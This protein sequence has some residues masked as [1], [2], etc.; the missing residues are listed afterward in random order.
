MRNYSI[1]ILLIT[2]FFTSCT[3]VNS[4]SDDASIISFEI[5]SA[6]DGI[7][8]NKE[9]IAIEN[10]VVSIPLEYGR[11]LFPLKINAEIQFSSTTDKAISTDETPLNLKELVFNDVYTPQTFY[12]ISE[13]GVPHLATIML[14]DNP[15]AEIKSFTIKAI[16]SGEASV[17]PL[18][19][20]IRIILTKTP[21]W[22]LTIIPE[23]IKTEDAT[24]I[25]YVAG[26]PLTFQSPADNEKH[27]TLKAKNGDE[28][29]W[30]IQI[31]PSIE[32]SD[33]ESWINENTSSVNIDP[34][35]G[36]GLGWATANNPF[37]QGTRPTNNNNGKAAQMTT[38]IQ[39]LSGLGIGQLITAGT[40]FTGYFK[41]NI[42]SLN[43]PAA[44]TYFGIPF[45]ISP[46]S[47]SV[48]AKYI[49]GN[50]L[51]Q[52]KKDGGK[53]KLENLAGT[54]E[55]RIWVKLL[56]WNGTGALEFHDKPVSGLTELGMGELILDGKNPLYREWKN[57][58]LPIKYSPAHSLLSPT[59]IAI[60][61][62]SSKQG[63]Y[64]IG[65][66]GSTLT[67]D[68]LKINY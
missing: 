5:K 20:N 29:T 58:T 55:G 36:K 21:A 11:K 32:N 49:P 27:I 56:H 62:T 15:N 51:Q 67:I 46:S 31:V 25:D 22:P 3:K 14:I 6:T 42:S 45:I 57:Y 19:N 9:N 48:D 18:N 53:Y 16:S 44:M 30:N 34:T 28:K 65:A 12:L 26:T 66:K 23:I 60:V 43:D 47:I 38:E 17:S 41:M 1:L 64:F 2:F 52:S 8:L 4:L 35:P 68:N 40:I 7:I 10:N 33:F 54:D 37:V 59:H 39:D 61:M 63:E 24:Y 50:Q 13:S